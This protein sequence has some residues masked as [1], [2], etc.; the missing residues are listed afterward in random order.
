MNSIIKTSHLWIKTIIKDFS[1]ELF[2]NDFVAIVGKN[3]AG[4]STLLKAILGLLQP[5]YGEIHVFGKSA[6]TL[7]RYDLCR[8]GYVPQVLNFDYRMPFTVQDVV[9]M[10]RYGKAGIGKKLTTHDRQKIQTAIND[11]GLQ[12]LKNRPIGVLSGGERQKVQIARVLCQEPDLLLLD[13]PTSHLDLSAQY[14]LLDILQQIYAEKKI[15]TLLVMHD[16]HDLP[17]MCN[18]AVV[19][20]QGTKHFEGSL[21]QLFSYEVLRPIYNN[22]TEKILTLCRHSYN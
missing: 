3:G 10:G 4:K 19:I 18:R 9:A 16:L 22:Y 6:K 1:F 7:N 15:A 11:L 17:E 13:E 5:A 12:G 8:I 20:H 21:S 14:E 2:Q